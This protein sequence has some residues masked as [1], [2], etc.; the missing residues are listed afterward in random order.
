METATHYSCIWKCL[1]VSQYGYLNFEVCLIYREWQVP[2]TNDDLCVYTLITSVHTRPLW[3]QLQLRWVGQF[4]GCGGSVCVIPDTSG[5]SLLGSWTS[6]HLCPLRWHT[7][8]TN[9]K[10]SAGMNLPNANLFYLN[11]CMNNKKKWPWLIH[12]G[13]KLHVDFYPSNHDHFQGNAWQWKRKKHI[14]MF[15]LMF[16]IKH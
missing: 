1:H 15:M 11:T 7:E 4:W 6:L 14:K 12:Y 13:L 10:T 16:M 5:Q 9:I 2:I 8:G 3:Y